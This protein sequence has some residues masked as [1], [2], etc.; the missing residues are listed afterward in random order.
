MTTVPLIP[1]Q[2]LFGNPDKAFVQISPAG[3]HL[4]WLAPRDG[5]LNVWVA[6]R[7]DPAAAQPVTHDTGRGVRFY[8]WAYT[9]RHILYIQDQG[10]DENW[11]MYSVELD[12]LAAK[13][14]T[15]FEGV[16]ARLWKTSPQ[17]PEEIIVGLNNRRP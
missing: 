6:P 12:T 16:A 15:P 1:R 8:I 14:L 7:D 13:D 11:R 4:A 3:R 9:S 17:R 2:L 10:G 5:V